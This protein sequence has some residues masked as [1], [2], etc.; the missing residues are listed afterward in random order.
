V[1]NALERSRNVSMVTYPTSTALT[2]FETMYVTASSV[3]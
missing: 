1:S 3:E 2:I